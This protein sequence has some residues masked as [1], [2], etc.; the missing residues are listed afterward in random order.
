[1]ELPFAWPGDTFAGQCMGMVAG[2]TPV[3]QTLESHDAQFDP[4]TQEVCET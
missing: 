3:Q 2:K 1:M 4:R